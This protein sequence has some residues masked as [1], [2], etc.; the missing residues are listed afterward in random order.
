[1]EDKYGCVK[2]GNELIISKRDNGPTDPNDISHE[3]TE[4]W[5]PFCKIGFEVRSPAHPRRN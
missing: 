2:C 1:M 3:I 5:C 4:F